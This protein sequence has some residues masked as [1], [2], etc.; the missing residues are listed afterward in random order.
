MV[1]RTAA[2][3]LNSLEAAAACCER[4]RL[5]SEPSRQLVL[6]R[7][8]CRERGWELPPGPGDRSD[9]WAQT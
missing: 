8:C 5:C 2:N 9:V 4:R 6:A 3:S 1:G 7:P